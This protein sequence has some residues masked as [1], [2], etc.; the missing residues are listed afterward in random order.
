MR[1]NNV[2][3]EQSESNQR[4]SGYN[5]RV[6]YNNR[7]GHGYNNRGRKST[8]NRGHSTINNFNFRGGSDRGRGDNFGE[9]IILI[10]MILNRRFN[11]IIMKILA[12]DNLNVNLKKI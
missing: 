2:I 6:G 4:N 3:K 9:K 12:I 10:R 11:I 5:N 1:S 7:G 8:P